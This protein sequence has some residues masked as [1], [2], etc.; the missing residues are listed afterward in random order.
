MIY[1][2][3]VWKAALLK[4]AR[5]L[6]KR[7]TQKRWPERAMA[8]VEREIFISAFSIRKLIESKKL[9]DQVEAI[10]LRTDSYEHTGHLVDIANWHKIEEL[11]NLSESEPKNL[12]LADFCNLI[13]HSLVFIIVLSSNNGLEGIFVTSDFKSSNYLLYIPINEVITALNAVSKDH[14]VFVHSERDT[15]GGIIKIKRKSNRHF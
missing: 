14:I 4:Q 8:H 6:Q 13:I 5:L 7:K 3:R 11:Y 1:E 10:L 15:L 2:S 9:S 12:K